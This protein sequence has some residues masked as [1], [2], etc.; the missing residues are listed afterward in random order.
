[1]ARLRTWS[2]WN[3]PLGVLCLGA[4]VWLGTWASGG[5][6]T[7]PAEAAP[8]RE[9]AGVPQ[10]FAAIVARVAPGVVTVRCEPSPQ[11]GAAAPPAAPVER[12]WSEPVFAPEPG[13]RT[14]SGFVVHARGLVVTSRHL[15]VAARRLEVLIPGQGPFAAEVVGEDV[16]TDLALL[17]LVAPPDDLTVLPLGSSEEL[18][19]GDWIVAVGNPLGFAQTVS[20]GVVS[21][22]GRHLHTDLGVTGDFLQFSAPVHP[23]SSGGPVFDVDG[24]V[25]GVTTQ[26]A[27]EAPGISFAVPSRTLRWTLDA[28][29]RTQD[30]KVRRGYLGIE[31]ATRRTAEDAGGAVITRVARGEPAERAGLQRGDVVLAVDGERIADAGSLHDR[32]LRGTPG[33]RIRLQLL[34]KG[35]VCEPV[36]A[37]LGEVGALR[38]PGTPN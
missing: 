14:G 34:R 32:I 29:L 7:I 2:N 38:A 35:R 1:M 10:S 9:P 33:S 20:A 3:L 37:V 27:T 15:V 17:R 19:A 11:A 30:G 25:V 21:Y 12:A 28:M 4:G 13:R 24:R 16:A 5:T 31:F 8:R 18:R 36:E 6:V 26:A 23:G 22:V